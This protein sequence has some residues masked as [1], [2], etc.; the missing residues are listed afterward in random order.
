M[1]DLNIAI[2]LRVN[3]AVHYAEE[4]EEVVVVSTAV[5]PLASSSHKE[6]NY[7]DMAVDVDVDM[8]SSEEDM[9]SA[10]IFADRAFHRRRNIQ[11]VEY[12]HEIHEDRMSCLIAQ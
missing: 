1:D 7:M 11:Y 9:T 5:D 4:E 2:C 8:D 3:M 12:Q 10:R 6:S